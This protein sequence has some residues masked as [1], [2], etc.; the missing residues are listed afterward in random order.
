MHAYA[1]SD[2]VFLA[3]NRRGQRLTGG[4]LGTFCVNCHAPLA[5]RE[6]ATTDGLNLESVDAKLQGVTCFFCHTADGV[7]GTHN[8]PL[9]LANEP[10]MRGPYSDPISNNVHRS[11]YSALHDRD[12][13][14]SASFCGSCHDVVTGH[15]AMLERTFTEWQAS[16]FSRAPGG[17]TCGQCHM[18]Q[19]SRRAP[20]A[21]VPDAPDRRR[22]SHTFTAVDVALTE[23]PQK[24]EQRA[25]IQAGLDSTLAMGLCVTTGRPRI[26]VLVDNVGAGHSFPSGSAQDRRLWAEV[27]AYSQGN[28]IYRSGAIGDGDSEKLNDPDLWL[29]RDCIFDT[30]GKEVHDFW[31]AASYDSNTL[32]ARKTFTVGDPAFFDSHVVRPFP[33]TGQLSADPDRVT[34]RMRLRPMSLDILDELIAGG[35]LDPAVR[36]AMPTFDVGPTL[37][38]TPATAQMVTLDQG[39]PVSC[40]SP[41]GFTVSSPVVPAPRHTR[42]SP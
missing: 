23:F 4:E 30:A 8:N 39:F 19:G 14:E 10:Q 15:G 40:V 41:T 36:S 20:I 37:E 6:K 33:T 21:N 32:A 35:D 16:V 7:E 9:R 29:I 12:Q 27:T 24:A 2:P 13:L 28:V 25:E 22:H 18:P 31:E 11:T 42:C 34:V 38:W 26:Q 3:M 1:S 5:V 17:T